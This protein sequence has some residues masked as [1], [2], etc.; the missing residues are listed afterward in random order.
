[1]SAIDEFSQLIARIYSAA[2]VPEEWDAAMAAIADAFTAHAAS[3]VVSDSVS[4]TLK[5]AQMPMSAAQAYAAHYERLDHVLYAVETGPEGV[6][7]TGA[8]LMWPYQNCEFQIDWARPNGLHDGLFVRLTS[9]TTMTSLAIAN[10]RQPERFDSPEH[11][12]LMHRLIPHLQQALRIQDR[13]EDLDRRNAD[14]AEA[15]EAVNH[16]IVIVEGR[17]Y[18]YANRAA[19][20]ILA[21]DDGLRIERGCITAESSHADTELGHS[22][23]RL[24][25]S[26][27][28][29]I[30][31]G[32]FLC[33]RPSGRRPYI[34][35]VLPVEANSF[36]AQ[37]HGRAMVI[38]VDPERQ[39]E[40]PAILLRRLYG[41]TNAEAQVALL[42][43]RG[44][45]LTPIAE[46]LSV[47]LT[48]VKT[49]LRHIFDKTGIHRQAELVR[50]LILLDPM[51]G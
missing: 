47:S 37:H 51:R 2:L 11:L 45:G 22:I 39:P 50:L 24:S 7:R 32:S 41:L 38:I 49:H 21:A 15:S 18:V 48:T 17:R 31:G 35:H 16:G 30:W 40:P 27:S 14:L 36:A 29:D 1:M 10:A 6:V 46:E 9:G 12:A 34:I 26:D 13:L 42:V 23:A 5:H 33:A 4:R 28:Q 44:E 3:L 20:R 43:M 25:K 8:E 19:E